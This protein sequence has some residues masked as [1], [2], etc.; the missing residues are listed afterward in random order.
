MLHSVGSLNRGGIETWLMNLVR[1]QSEEVQFDFVVGVPGGVYEEE[2][3]RH[4]CRVYHQP[5]RT[6]LQRR[7]D[8]LGV[9]RPPR[10]LEEI[11]R[12]GEYDVLHVHGD[13]FFGDAMGVAATCGVAVRVAHCHNT[14]VARGK[15]GPEMTLRRARFKTLDRWRTL[16]HATHIVA[17]SRE[18]GEHFVGGHWETDPRCAAVY[19]AVAL[20]QFSA[21][22]ACWTREAFRRAHRIPEGAVV[23]GHVGSMDLTPQKNYE[24]LLRVFKALAERSDEYYLY[25]AGEGPRRP[26]LHAE[27]QAAG[28]GGRTLLPGL[29]DD[30]PSLMMHGFD[31]LLLPSL[32]E[33]LPV[34]GLEAVASGLHTVCS[35]T[36]TRDF[37]DY[38]P[39]RVTTVPLDASP[40]IWADRTE[41]AVRR[42]M[43][44]AEGAAM[45][46]TSPFSIGSSLTAL[47]D[48]YKNGLLRG[49]T[50]GRGVA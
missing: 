9:L 40:E 28:L 42:R 43:P 50:A 27:I 20:V 48:L 49:S 45:L 34:V 36:I 11:L 5:L 17:C 3:R 22:G 46:R 1:Q 35:D 13:E 39:T 38:F 30:V 37:T 4:G 19:C 25:L 2:A 10:F 21:S 18:A 12:S 14:Q 24:Q 8:V 32:F 29:C 33:G 16:R 26:L 31:V 41:D 7:L 23:V 6:R 15:S 44:G 47:I